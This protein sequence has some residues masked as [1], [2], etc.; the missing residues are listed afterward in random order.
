[1]TTLAAPRRGRADVFLSPG[2]YFVGDAHHRI[3]TILGSCVSVTLWSDHPRVGAM[4]HF[5]LA[6]RQVG[7]RGIG[8]VRGLDLRTLDARYGD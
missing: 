6:S 1:M 4:S 5:L 2:D 3:R 7:E 8:D